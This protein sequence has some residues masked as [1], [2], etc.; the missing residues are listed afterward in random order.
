[1][2]ISSDHYRDL[3]RRLDSLKGL[4]SGRPGASGLRAYFEESLAANELE[5]ALHA[6]CA[7]LLDPSA[8]PVSGTVAEQVSELHSL[9]GLE[10]ECVYKLTAKIV[11]RH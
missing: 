8:P 9:M 5:V 10:D 7:F 6:L 11:D 2:D 1:M 3:I 4:F